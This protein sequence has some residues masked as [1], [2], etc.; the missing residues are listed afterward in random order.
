MSVSQGNF[1]NIGFP[2]DEHLVS[3]LKDRAYK[4]IYDDL[5]DNRAYNIRMLDGA[6]LQM[7]YRFKRDKI[8]KHR[9]AF[10]PSP[11]L[12]D[13]QNYPEIY[14][15]DEIYADIIMKDIVVFP[16]RFDFDNCPGI[17]TPL[18]HPKSHLTL[19]NY[20]NCRIPVTAPLTP[21]VFVDFILRNFYN[22]AHGNY[23]KCFTPD[24][25]AFENTIDVIENTVICIN[26]PC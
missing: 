16:I 21:H 14:E 4:D 9:L 19:G 26:I 12:E 24:S 5:N 7:T 3:T 1:T 8:E 23:E 11:Y 22:T 25:G 18:K 10:L 20:K 17:S 6:M 13:F 2:G 15:N